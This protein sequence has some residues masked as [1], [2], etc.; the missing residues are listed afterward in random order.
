M[1]HDWIVGVL[2]DLRRFALQN[3]LPL[4]AEELKAAAEVAALELTNLA[5]A[6]TATPGATA[7]PATGTEKP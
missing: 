5:E 3:G 6:A 4:L 2:S 7:S 1:P